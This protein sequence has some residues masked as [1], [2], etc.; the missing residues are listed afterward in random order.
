MFIDGENLTYDNS[1]D[2]FSTIYSCP[3]VTYFTKTGKNNEG[4][5]GVCTGNNAGYLDIKDL[6][7]VAS[8]SNT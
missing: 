8:C 6:E 3:N 1:K 5:L 2:Y 7:C 4:V